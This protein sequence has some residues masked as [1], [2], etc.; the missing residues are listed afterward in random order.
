[1]SDRTQVEAIALQFFETM[2]T[3][4]VSGLPLSKQVEYFG[5][6]TPEPIRG[7][8]EVRE[9]LQQIAPFMLNVKHGKMIIEGG[10]VAALVEFDVVN[11]IH[12]KGAYFLE[13][14]AGEICLLR[15]IFDSHAMMSGSGA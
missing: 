2:S 7:E 12:V 6:L 11:G 1:L 9:H 15:A 8:F 3:D 10:A 13:V 4:D 5:I 14:V